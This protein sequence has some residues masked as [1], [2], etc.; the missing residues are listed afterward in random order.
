VNGT[1]PLRLEQPTIE[2]FDPLVARNPTP[3]RERELTL[4]VLTQTRSGTRDNGGNGNGGNGNGDA[5]V[6]EREQEETEDDVVGKLQVYLTPG[7]IVA[8]LPHRRPVRADGD[9]GARLPG[10]RKPPAG[11]LK[12]DR[13]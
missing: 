2:L 4:S 10:H 7:V 1:S 12:E 9:P 11:V 13:R 3:E 6:V 5:D 8:P